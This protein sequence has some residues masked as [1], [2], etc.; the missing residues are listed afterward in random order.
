MRFIKLFRSFLLDLY[1]NRHVVVQLTKRDYKNAYIGSFLGFIWSIVQP[2]ATIFVLWIVFTYG[3]KVDRE[4]GGVPFLAYLTMGLVVWNFF[5][6][7]FSS[8][9][10]VFKQYSYL[11]KKIN[12]KVAILP[13]VKVLSNFVTHIVFI[14]VGIAILLISG[15]EPS[16]YW[17][18]F[19]YYL[20]SLIV[21]LLALGWITSSIQVFV[22]D[23][24][25]VIKILVD[26]GFWFTPIIWDFQLVPSKYEIYFKLNP[27]YYIVDGYRKSFLYEEPFWT[28]LDDMALFW[29]ITLALLVIAV[30]VFSRLRPH[31]SDV[32]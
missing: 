18:Q 22:R 19:V 15:V 10:N 24:S 17:L 13:L 28:D 31:F 7:S 2:I 23:L 11:L 8:T 6:V 26:F 29:G 9:T 20:F 12:F 30:V 21:L 25:Q 16:V 14:F 32:L 1:S 4:I 27:V 5:A 3:F